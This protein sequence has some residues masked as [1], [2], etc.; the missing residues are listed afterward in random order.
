MDSQGGP[1]PQ[2]GLAVHSD[3]NEFVKNQLFLFLDYGNLIF[4]RVLFFPSHV[5]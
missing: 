4:M 5:F 2:Q 1:D 3:Q